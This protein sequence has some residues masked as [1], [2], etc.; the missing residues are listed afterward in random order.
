M[1]GRIVS[2]N[3]GPWGGAGMITP[4]LEREYGRRGIGLIPLEEGVNRLFE[5]LG[6][7]DAAQ[8]L[9]MHESAAEKFRA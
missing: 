9:L 2:I 3:W 7:G 5:E 4:E 6:R 1:L 8:V